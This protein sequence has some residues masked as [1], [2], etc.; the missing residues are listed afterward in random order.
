MKLSR[1]I[2]QKFEK[3]E[4]YYVHYGYDDKAKNFVNSIVKK[5]PHNPELLY[6]ISIL[7][8]RCRQYETAYQYIKLAM[9]YGKRDD[10]CRE[11]RQLLIEKITS[12]LLVNYPPN[13]Q[14]KIINNHRSEM[15]EKMERLSIKSQ[16]KTEYSIA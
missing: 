8:A 3:L 12:E 10:C 2:F 5:D 6:G 15:L 16:T 11:T 1:E 9:E 7:L 4:N 14:P 13:E